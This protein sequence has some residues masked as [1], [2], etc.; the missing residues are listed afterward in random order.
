M[1][2]LIR[3]ERSKTTMLVLTRQPGE[4]IFIH[5]ENGNTVEV[6]ILSSGSRRVSLGI[7]APRSIEVSRDNRRQA[8]KGRVA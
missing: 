4:S 8:D 1:T 2:D 5:S 3:Y 7:D 6:K